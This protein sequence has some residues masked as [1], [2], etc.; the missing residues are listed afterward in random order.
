M[1][2]LA[3]HYAA[4]QRRYPDDDL[5]I[6]FDID[7]TI[8]DMRHMVLHVLLE[9]DRAHA[10]E[11]F[12]GLCVAD[13]DVHENRLE[14]L[15]VR[16]DVPEEIR[17][18]VLSWYL[19]Q[20]WT[21][22]AILASHRPYQ[23]VMDIIRW[24]QLQPR[25]YVGLNTGRPDAIRRDT[26]AS[27]NALGLEYRVHFENE[28]LHMN[29]GAWEQGV[30]DVKVRNLQHFRAQGFRVIAVV[31]NEPANLAAMVEADP[32]GEILFLHAETLFE[33]GRLE[34]PRSVVGSSYDI[35][36]LLRAQDVPRHV[37]LVWRDI[38][39]RA[40]LG[41]FLASNIQWGECIL[42]RDPL[43]RVVLRRTS[44]RERA[45]H[46][47]EEDLP[48]VECVRAFER[49]GKSLEADLEDDGLLDDV[50]AAVSGFDPHRLCFNGTIEGLGEHGFRR[51]RSAHPGAVLQSPIDFL[52]PMLLGVPSK[53]R[54]ILEMLRHWGVGRFSLSWSQPAVRRIF[55]RLRAWGYEV[56]LH[57]VP[58]LEGFLQAA[59]LLPRS[60]TAGFD[61][62]QW[63]ARA[64]A[65][66]E[67]E[68]ER[69]LS[70]V[71]AR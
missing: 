22:A 49:A 24:F 68:H 42:R 14:P 34:I 37:Q 61:F 67:H 13:I 39:D 29:T 52:C 57:N 69:E 5:M 26:L 48:L 21:S 70:R 54:E 50:L 41:A 11:H 20:R 1:R 46:R 71:S 60:L 8:L 59:L 31:D 63:R 43:G 27:L 38:D 7:G 33:S 45:W 30:Q 66:I 23:G 12:Y 53:A 44:F 2:N 64:T 65:G 16:L 17:Q 58:D 32:D 9:Y 4:A 36:G 40:S 62:P 15:L 28:L 47:A 18:N 10:S 55:E 3:D 19:A 51:I 25:T 56:N 6:V 35:T